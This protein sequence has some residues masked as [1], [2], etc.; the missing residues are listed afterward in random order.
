VQSQKRTVVREGGGGGGDRGPHFP[1][2]R[3]GSKC[4][5][6]SSQREK[7]STIERSFNFVQA[8]KDGRQKKKKRR[9]PPCPKEKAGC[10]WIG[11]K[12]NFLHTSLKKTAASSLTTEGKGKSCLKELLLPEK[13]NSRKG[14]K[15]FFLLSKKG[16]GKRER[17]LNFQGLGA[18]SKE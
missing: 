3:G 2:A 5:C 12:E 16:E 6:V 1:P 9:F 18:K 17:R 13:G 7:N 10:A 15:A 4:H 8:G 14:G 11:T